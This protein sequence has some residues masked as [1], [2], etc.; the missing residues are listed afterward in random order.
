M[1]CTLDDMKCS[2]GTLFHRPHLLD[3]GLLLLPRAVVSMRRIAQVVK[4]TP[5]IQDGAYTEGEAGKS[6]TVE[7]RHVYFRYPGAK[8][9]ALSNINFQARRGETVVFI[10]SNGC[11]KTPL[12]TLIPRLYAVTDGDAF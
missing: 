7:F 8:E 5:A 10:G 4:T 12:L 2:A 6:G 3:Q 11:G 1:K 9:Y